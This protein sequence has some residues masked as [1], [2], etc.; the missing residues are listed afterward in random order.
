M[1]KVYVLY[2]ECKKPYYKWTTGIYSS[3]KKAYARL[4]ALKSDRPEYNY[5]VET[6][7]LR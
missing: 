2:S 6:E 4:N 1:R 3:K 7:I 5:Y